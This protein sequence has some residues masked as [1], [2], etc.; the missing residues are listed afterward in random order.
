M[1]FAF[2]RTSVEGGPARWDR[3]W[4]GLANCSRSEASMLALASAA[5]AAE[6]P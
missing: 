2:S 5:E 1:I 6:T 4:L 3:A